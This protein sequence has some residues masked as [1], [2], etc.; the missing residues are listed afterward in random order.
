MNIRAFVSQ[1]RLEV[2]IAGDA[3]ALL[4]FV[5]V[6]LASHEMNTNVLW[7]LVRIA[8][9]FL[10]GWFLVAPFTQ[11]YDLSTV[12][13]TGTFMRRSAITWL[14][15][16]G[17]GLLLRATLFREGFVPTFALVTLIVTGLFLLGWRSIFARL[18]SR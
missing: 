5:A 1:R 16:I 7:N 15:G 6:G 8:T 9:P 2:L 14:G 12:Q 18:L 13:Q 10:L 3:A 4:L 17:L 11:A